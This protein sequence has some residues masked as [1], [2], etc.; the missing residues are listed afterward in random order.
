MP[1]S[2]AGASRGAAR[3]GRRAF[4]SHYPGRPHATGLTN[5][6]FTLPARAFGAKGLAIER[7]EE[8]DAVL[9]EAMATDGPVLVE[10]RTSLENVDAKHTIAGLRA[11]A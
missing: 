10:A 4:R 9:A 3:P 6:D 11:R 1:V 7:A 2:R 5:P 8:A